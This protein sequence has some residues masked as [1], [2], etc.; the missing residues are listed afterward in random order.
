MP[1]SDDMVAPPTNASAAVAPAS[2]SLAA[3]MGLR[4]MHP[5]YFAMAMATGIVSVACYLVGFSVLA[6]A[7][8][9]LNVA[10]YAGLWAAMLLRLFLYPANVWADL[11]SHARGVGFFTTVAATCVLG[12]Q[13]LVVGGL[14]RAAL[15]LWVL[16]I[17]LWAALTYGV[18]A[19]LTIRRRKPPLSVGIHGGWLVAV[20]AAQSVAVLGAQLASRLAPYE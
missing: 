1:S 13:C 17:V 19:A 16:G 11:T 9:W 12:T 10:V 7:L 3:S 18:F 15:I 20:V 8:F 5:A 2:S 14:P 6:K 4:D